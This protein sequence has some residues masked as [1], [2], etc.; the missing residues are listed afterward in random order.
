[1]SRPARVCIAS[2]V[3]S[4]R[5]DFLVGWQ[6]LAIG[7]SYRKICRFLI[8]WNLYLLLLISFAIVALQSAAML[9]V[10]LFKRMN[11]EKIPVI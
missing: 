11:A 4:P 1:M 8:R 6:P 3:G 2:W 10:L 9:A 7:S 5:H